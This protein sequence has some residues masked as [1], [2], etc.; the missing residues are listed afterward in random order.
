MANEAALMKMHISGKRYIA[1]AR[2]ACSH[3]AT[4][5]L[6]RQI[7]AIHEFAGGHGMRCV[8]KVRLA[9]VGGGAPAMREDLQ[10]LLARKREQDDFDV[11]VIEDC[12]RLTR[13]GIT[14]GQ[15]IETEFARC[16]V[17]IVY[18]TNTI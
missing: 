4:A 16:G 1:Y 15:Q 2:C 7:R 17:Q 9:G 8:G 3:R 6:D 10:K 14:E 11:L 18:L 12:A 13:A 5:K